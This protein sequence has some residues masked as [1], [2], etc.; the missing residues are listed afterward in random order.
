M[1]LEPTT[2]KIRRGDQ[3]G[4]AHEHLGKATDGLVH[5]FEEKIDIEESEDTHGNHKFTGDNGVM[6]S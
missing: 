1:L 2:K 5:C 4:Q 3:I 6:V